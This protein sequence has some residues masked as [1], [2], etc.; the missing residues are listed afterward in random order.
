MAKHK[1][2]YYIE[3]LV[4]NDATVIRKIYDQFAPR[5]TGYVENNSGTKEDAR[6]IFQE[7]LLAILKKARSENFVLTCPFGAFLY[8][9]CSR[10]WLNRLK[11]KSVSPVTIMDEAGFKDVPSDAIQLS[12][13]TIWEQ[14]RK[15]LYLE[16]LNGL[17]PRCR[18]IIK[19]S[20]SGISMQE[21]AKKLGMSYAYARKKKSECLATLLEN[22]QSD[23]R[24]QD[25]KQK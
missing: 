24:Y 21:V 20:L 1:D 5:I 12:E 11:Q 10:K 8:L 7:G 19:T 9:V 16:K 25:L 13:T 3:G 14:E 17:S 2:Q 6:D 4:N 15:Q 23:G 22:I 18:E